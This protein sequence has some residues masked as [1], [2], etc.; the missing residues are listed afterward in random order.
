[1]LR[2]QG[3]DERDAGQDAE[4]VGYKYY[5]CQSCGEEIVD[6]KQLHQVA[7]KY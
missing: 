2:M 7:E 4:G 1:M 5:K 3:P 6:M